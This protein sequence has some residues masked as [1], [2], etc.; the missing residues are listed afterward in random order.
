MAVGLLSL[1]GC[2]RALRP[3][4]RSS[5]LRIA[6]LHLEVRV[7]ERAHN[8]ALLQRAMQRAAEA[9]ARWVVTPEL[10]ITGYHFDRTLGV[11]WLG[12][13]PD[14]FIGQLAQTC[15]PHGLTLFLGHLERPRPNGPAYNTLFVIDARGTILGAHRKIQVIPQ[16][17][18]WASPGPQPQLLHVDG[19]AVGLLLCADAWPPTHAAHLREQGAEIL[20][21][22]ATWP[23]G[24]HG[25]GDTWEKRSAETGLPL[26]VANRTGCEPG[27]DVRSARTVVAQQGRRLVAHQ[28]EHSAVVL[29]DWSRDG[30]TA[31]FVR[32]LAL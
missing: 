25:P 16:A 29:I 8:V 9:G 24:E 12:P 15:V 13:A 27:F 7:G 23:E 32:T 28:S 4:A 1:T 10:A 22:A 17:E 20:V 2:A 14:R 30:G 5:A 21:S 19:V 11:D 18:D 6:L 26:L 3:S 31:A